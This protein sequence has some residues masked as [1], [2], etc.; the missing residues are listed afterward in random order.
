MRAFRQTE[1]D[2]IAAVNTGVLFS[3]YQ[4]RTVLDPGP[5]GIAGTADD[6]T[7]TVFE[8]DPATFGLDHFLLT[9]PNGLRMDQRGIVAEGG[10][11]KRGLSLQASIYVGK[12]W[13][14]TNPGND[15]WENDSGVVGS[16][17]ADPNTMIN[18]GDSPAMD[19]KVAGKVLLSW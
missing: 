9:N 18:A 12:S 8:Q 11:D 1:R 4:P 10:F 15:I 2:R 6:R 19:R 3:A 5:D 14:P 13:G 16:L 7:L 17:Y